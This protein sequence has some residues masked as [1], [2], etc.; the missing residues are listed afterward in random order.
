MKHAEL[1]HIGAIVTYYSVGKALPFKAR[2]EKVHRPGDPDSP[3]DLVAYDPGAKED[4]WRPYVPRG[5]RSG[6]WDWPDPESP[7]DAAPRESATTPPGRGAPKAA[8]QNVS[9]E[10]RPMANKPAAAAPDEPLP[11]ITVT[12]ELFTTEVFRVMQGDVEL[13]RLERDPNNSAPVITLHKDDQVIEIWREEAE[14][15][16]DALKHFADTGRL[17]Q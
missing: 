3:V 12:S 10:T 4:A 6:C 8:P 15:I 13:A 11:P 1:P 2:I 16:A 9:Q 17:D 5:R 7:K 14:H